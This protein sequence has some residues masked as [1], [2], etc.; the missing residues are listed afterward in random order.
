MSPG[1]RVLICATTVLTLF[2]ISGYIETEEGNEDTIDDI[3]VC[4]TCDTGGGSQAMA[5]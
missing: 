2:L 1:F 4:Y 3:D 5:P